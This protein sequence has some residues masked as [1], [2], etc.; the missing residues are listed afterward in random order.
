MAERIIK[1]IA[2]DNRSGAAEILHRASEALSLLDGLEQDDIESA[3]RVVISTCADIARAQPDMAP[4]VN[5]ASAVVRAAHL[6]TR[7]DEVMQASAAAA[8]AFA[9]NAARAVAAAVARA[10]DLI[11]NGTTI[12]TH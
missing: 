3:R 2:E 7:A 5:L 10:A 11:A 1:Q 8:C 9:D 12:L 6:A 4:L